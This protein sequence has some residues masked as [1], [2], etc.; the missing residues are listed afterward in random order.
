VTAPTV[1]K[2]LRVP[3]RLSHSPISLATAYPHGGTAIGTVGKVIAHPLDPAF[4]VTAVEF[5]GA[6]ID[7]I[8]GGPRWVVTFELRELLD[9]DALAA[10][11]PCYAAGASGG[12]I[13]KYRAGTNGQRAGLRVGASLAFVLVFTPDNED[14]H[15]W[16]ILRRAVPAIQETAEIALR[17]N[18]DAGL[19]VRWYATPDSNKDVF[20]LGLRRDLTL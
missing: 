20:D 3:G 6:P 4:V 12:P 8:E 16:L 13:L 7:L 10:I 19:A 5:G 1:A 17:G 14:Q 18:A 11:F 9:P 2:I 15:P